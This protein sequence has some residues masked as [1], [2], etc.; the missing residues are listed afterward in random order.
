M[1]AVRRGLDAGPIGAGL[2]APDGDVLRRGQVVTHEV[3]EDHAN[4]RTQFLEVVLAGRARRAGCDPRRVVEAGQK[5]HQCRLARSVLAD[6]RQHLAGA[7]REGEMS[8]GP[9]FGARVAEP[10]VLEDEPLAERLRDG[11]RIGRRD[12]LRLDLEEGEQVVEVER[13]PCHL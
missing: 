12:D 13:L 8:Y 11:A 4:V 9:A 5:L 6:E 2:D 7:E 1:A 3:L 10:H